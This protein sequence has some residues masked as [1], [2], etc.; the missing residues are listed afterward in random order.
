M[1]SGYARMV[2]VLGVTATVA[3]VACGSGTVAV[4]DDPNLETAFENVLVQG[5]T[6]T[7]GEIAEEAGIDGSSWDRMYYFSVPLLMSEVNRMLGTAGVVWEG[8]PG[9]GAEGLMVF[10][11]DGEIV[12]AVTDYEPPLAL[13]GFATADS[14]VSPGD[15]VGI[16]RVSVEA[17]GR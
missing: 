16:P 11:S 17:K 5:E 2:V 14:V 9:V 1:A 8:L 7:L 3:A 12:H 6:R 13:N 15:L 4:V 10:T